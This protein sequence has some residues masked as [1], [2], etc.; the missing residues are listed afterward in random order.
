MKNSLYLQRVK[1]AIIGVA[2]AGKSSIIDRYVNNRFGTDISTLGVGLFTVMRDQH[3]FEIWDTCGQERFSPLL[4]FYT[5]GSNALIITFDMSNPESYSPKSC[6][7]IKQCV[8]HNENLHCI[9]LVMNKCDN[10]IHINKCHSF[11]Q[12]T[13]M[14]MFE[15][16]FKNVEILPMTCS[17][18]TG[19]NIKELFNALFETC[20]KRIPIQIAENV[21]NNTIVNQKNRFNNMMSCCHNG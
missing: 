21:E 7:K 20:M 2:G 12:K 6:E 13:I 18:K 3:K 4:H 16:E 8:Y 15:E 19:A 1:V 9:A 14:P 5:R 17:A 11:L 10:T